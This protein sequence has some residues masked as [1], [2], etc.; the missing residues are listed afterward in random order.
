MSLSSSSFYAAVCRWY[1]YLYQIY[2]QFAWRVEKDE[3]KVHGDVFKLH[4]VGEL[5]TTEIPVQGLMILFRTK[6]GK[7]LSSCWCDVSLYLSSCDLRGDGLCAN[8][9]WSDKTN[10]QTEVVASGRRV[11]EIRN[12]YS[13]EWED[14]NALCNGYESQFA[15]R[16]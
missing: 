10:W 14:D 16:V 15:L 8:R 6:C 5:R 3:V 9:L 13:N 2:S 1:F 11:P 4:W 12:S 7:S